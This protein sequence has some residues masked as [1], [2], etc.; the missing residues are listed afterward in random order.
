MMYKQK[1]VKTLVVI[2]IVLLL[3]TAVIFYNMGY[4]SA[5]VDCWQGKLKVFGILK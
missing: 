3:L 1:I 4:Q 2:S 5:K